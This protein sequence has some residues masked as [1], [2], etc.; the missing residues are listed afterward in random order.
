MLKL[1]N[2]Q[3]F[4]ANSGPIIF[5]SPYTSKLDPRNVGWVEHTSKKVLFLLT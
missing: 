5:L 4:L 2:D 3:Y 1:R